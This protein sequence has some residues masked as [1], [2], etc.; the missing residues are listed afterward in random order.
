M[1]EPTP[2][3][4]IHGANDNVTLWD[5]APNDTYWGPYPGIEEV[6]DYL[7]D[8]NGC[9][10]NENL[11]L[12]NFNTIK[13]RYYDCIDNWGI[14]EQSNCCESQNGEPNWTECP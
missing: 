12:S 13:H 1:A 5:G 3:L 4:E 10:S 9:N 8:L 6:I 11:L 2:V 14:Q 7:V